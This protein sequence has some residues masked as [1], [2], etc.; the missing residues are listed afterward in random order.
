MNRHS[1]FS[2]NRGASE[3]VSYMLSLA[4]LVI[5]VSSIALAGTQHMDRI[6]NQQASNQMEG[7]NQQIA[8]EYQFL[9]QT[10]RS[11]A[12]PRSAISRSL[13][14]S[15]SVSGQQ[16]QIDVEYVSSS[17][18]YHRYTITLSSGQGAE[19]TVPIETRVPIQET[20]IQGGNIEIVRPQPTDENYNSGFCEAVPEGRNSSTGDSD[21][22]VAGSITGTNGEPGFQSISDADDDADIDA[23]DTCKL[24]MQEAQE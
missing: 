8:Y 2:D 21:S 16:Y 18:K 13:G 14:L 15:K 10:V 17:D 12:N 7:L 5:I 11:D 9:D 1:F 3:V 20:S 23:P 4:I 6:T 19:S 22:A 24:T